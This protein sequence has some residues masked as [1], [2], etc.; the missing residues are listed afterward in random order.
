MFGFDVTLKVVGDETS[1]HKQTL[2]KICFGRCNPMITEL[3]R[4]QGQTKL[5]LTKDLNR[6]LVRLSC[7]LNPEAGKLCARVQACFSS[8]KA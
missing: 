8:V 5:C 6:D 7:L 4:I 3:K 1:L 2:A